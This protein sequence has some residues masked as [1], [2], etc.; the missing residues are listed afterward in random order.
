MN[1]HAPR[2]CLIVGGGLAGLAAATSLGTRGISVTLLE[3]RS[4]LGGRAGSFQDST[5]GQLIDACQHV[6]MGCCTSF[7]A[8]CKTV[9]IDDLLEPQ[10]ALHFMTPDGRVSRFASDPWPAPFHLGRALAG[11]HYLTPGEKLRIGY[12]LMQLFRE[13]AESDPPLLDWLK[14]HWQTE[15]TISR[16]WS[17]VLTSALNET[18][19][20]VGLKYA[21][22]VFVDGFLSSRDGWTVW[23]PKVP[24][25]ELYGD[26]LKQFL[27]RN[28]ITLI[29]N[30]ALRILVFDSVFRAPHSAL[31][32]DGRTFS[33]DAIILAVPFDRV[34][35]LL[36]EN[37][38]ADPYF[39]QITNLT[40]SPITSVHLWTDQPLT[41]L[42]HIVFVDCLCQWAFAKSAGNEHYL[43]VV[44]SAAHDLKGLGREEITRRVVAELWKLLPNAFH[45][46]LL[47]S[48]VV[49]EHTA[50]FSAVPGVDAFRPT[51][52]TPIPG[53]YLAGDWTQTGWPATMEG[54]VRSGNLAAEEILKTKN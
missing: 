10:P 5:T 30:A 37:L 28:N 34:L 8:F 7:F 42:P 48:K 12:G 46:N 38:V 54:A 24:L 45:A 44:V 29:E 41:H 25:G 43:Q 27:I 35:S 51:Q 36:P 9:G 16:F 1:S 22:K 47:R 21:R 2:S 18:V 13:P 31:L 32:R 3:A 53:L 40:P 52:R 49:T 20:R 39:S 26:R 6:A 15:R 23:V 11:A 19:D 17:V 4:R 50:T 33:T 14:C